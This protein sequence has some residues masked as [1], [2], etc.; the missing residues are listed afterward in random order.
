M[1]IDHDTRHMEGDEVD[2]DFSCPE[3]GER[4]VDWLVWND[5]GTAVTCATCNTVYV[6]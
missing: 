3:C 1:M 2:E 4:R 5:E 6:P